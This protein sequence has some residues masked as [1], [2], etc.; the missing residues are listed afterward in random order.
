MDQMDWN[1]CLST[2]GNHLRGLAQAG[3]Y[4]GEDGEP[5]QIRYRR[6]KE[7][8][9]LLLDGCDSVSD[10]QVLEMVESLRKRVPDLAEE[11]AVALARELLG[12]KEGIAEEQ[13]R[14]WGVELLEMADASQEEGLDNLYDIGRYQGVR[15][16]G[17]K[18]RDLEF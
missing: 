13:V 16:L 5:G 2:W 1:E 15:V 9:Q 8:A 12:K 3:L 11:Q 4:Y 7:I 10:D 18:M 6:M 17:E 14:A